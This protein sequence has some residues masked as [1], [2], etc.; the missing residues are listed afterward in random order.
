[1]PDIVLISPYEDIAALGIRH[2]TSFMKGRGYS[3]RQIYMPYFGGPEV[4]NGETHILKRPFYSDA[5][6]HEVGK[7]CRDTDL[8]GITVMTNYVSEAISLTNYIQREHGKKVVWGGIHPTVAPKMCLEWADYVCTGEAEDALEEL[9]LAVKHEKDPTGIDNLAGK[10]S[11]GSVYI[12]KQRP[13]V[14]DLDTLPHPDYTC[15]DDWLI[16]PGGK[17][18]FMEP[19]IL[20]EQLS[21]G[22][23]SRIHGVVAYQTMSS[24]GC[25]HKCTYCCNNALQ[26]MYKGQKFTRFRS[27]DNIADEIEQIIEKYPWVQSIGFSDDCFFAR[28]VDKFREFA[29]AYKEK[30]GLPYNCLVTPPSVNRPKMDLAVESGARMIQMGIETASKKTMKMYLRTYSQDRMMEACNVIADYCDRMRRPHYD[31]IIN[32]PLETDE[33]HLETLQFIVDIPYPYHLQLFS[34][35]PYPGTELV[36]MYNRA[37]YDTDFTN[38]DFRM[39]YSHR[40]INY[41]NICYALLSRNFNKDLMRWMVKPEVYR[42]FSRPIFN[43]LGEA[44]YKAYKW[45]RN[46]QNRRSHDSL[47]AAAAPQANEAAA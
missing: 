19:A 2:L 39:D 37:G 5:T 6:L 36:T 8:V 24:R 26:D 32:N 44:A 1:M 28:N 47:P 46:M 3:V 38:P 29:M 17:V 14:Q 11:D 9:Y 15:E 23:I 43:H 40:Q 31:L 21:K 33:D 27:A 42:F 30:V 45:V 10:R 35:V 12:N 34:L 18:Q 4:D 16:Q 20:R 25:P 7:L 41:Q 22:I 13:L